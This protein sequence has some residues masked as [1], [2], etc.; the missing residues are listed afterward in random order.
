MVYSTESLEPTMECV[1]SQEVELPKA[2]VVRH[3][4][5]AIALEGDIEAIK[6][7]RSIRF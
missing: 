7:V 6:A 4:V 5:E 1:W 2:Q 3:E